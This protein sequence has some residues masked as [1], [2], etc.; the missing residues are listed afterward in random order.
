MD[1]RATVRDEQA[2][3]KSGDALVQAILPSLK[4]KYGKWGF[5]DD[6]AAANVSDTAQELAGTKKLPVPVR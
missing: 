2:K 5:F 4:S 1:L 6:L 3:G